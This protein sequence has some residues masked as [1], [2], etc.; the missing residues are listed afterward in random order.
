MQLPELLNAILDVAKYL[1]NSRGISLLLTDPETGDLVFTIV[2]GVGHDIIMKEKVPFGKGIVGTVAQTGQPMI[3]NNPQKDPRFFKEIDSKS[4]F[5][6]INILCVP[7]MVRG[8]LVG[9]LE[10]VNST[11]KDGFDEWDKKLLSYIADQA[12]IAVFNRKL[13]DE[14]TNRIAEITALYEITQAV[15]NTKKNDDVLNTIIQAI[16]N[17]LEYEK[18]SLAI[19]DPVKYKMILKASYGFPESILPGTEIDMENSIV[20]QVYKTGDPIMVKDREKDIAIPVPRESNYATKSFISAPVRYQNTIIGVLNI[21][22]KKDGSPFDSINLRTISTIANHVGEAYQNVQY[23]KNLEAQKRLAQ[24]IDIAAEIQKRILPK[25]PP[26]YKSH[27]MAAF[28]KPAKE[29]GGDFYDFYPTDNNK[30]AVLVGDVS[31][32]GIPA[33]LFMGSA[34]NIIRA[35]MRINSKPASVLYNSNKY[36]YEDSEYGMF[37]TLFYA[38]ID[39][40]N[41]IFTYGNAGHNDQ[42]LFTGPQKEIIRLNAR[43]KVLGPSPDA[44]YEEKVAYYKPGDMLVI[45]TD[46]VTEYLGERDIEKGESRLIDICLKNFS[47][48]PCD[49]LDFFKNDLAINTLDNDFMDDFTIVCIKF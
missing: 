39:V 4:N 22:D 49:F 3:V 30:Y 33:A 20:G 38:L 36:I 19:F 40:Q 2:S 17:S 8:V 5:I 13:L 24:E 37:V 12:A 35:E 26:V 28:N 9:V 34:K 10:A 41:N 14:L 21:T 6:T 27:K 18:C 46:G 45:F 44:A 32:K 31:G 43:G 16:A 1:V 29:V 23:H 42:F 48:D 7:M 47:L 15:T 11:D 25:F